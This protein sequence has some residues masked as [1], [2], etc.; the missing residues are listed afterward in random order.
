MSTRNDRSA[1]LRRVAVLTAVAAL[2]M[3]PAGPAQVRAG[4][5]P[6]P[7]IDAIADQT[8]AEG[9]F[10]DVPIHATNPN[11]WPYDGVILHVNIVLSGGLTGPELATLIDHHDGTG[12]LHIA[13]G[14]GTAGTYPGASV[15][16][17]GTDDTTE[18]VFTLTVTQPNRRPV[19]AVIA[20]QTVAEGATKDVDV[21]ASDPDGDAVAISGSLPAFATLTDH[22]DGTA[23][24]HLAPGYSDAGTYANRTVDVYDGHLWGA[25]VAFG[26]TV[27]NTDQTAP[28][29]S[30]PDAI[31]TTAN[32][33]H[34]AVV[35][36]R[37]SASDD[38]DGS[39]VPTCVPPSGS[40]FAVGRTRVTCSVTDSS[41]HTASASFV[42]TV[43]RTAPVPSVPD[44]SA[45]QP[46]EP[47]EPRPA[48]PIALGAVAMAIASLWVAVGRAQRRRAR[49]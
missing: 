31:T 7:T 8:V 9:A 10:A 19:L 46:R 45:G 42:V 4:V 28:V 38:V 2:L 13:P 22:H 35:T 12:I 44:T 24:I 37:V 11:P 25:Q 18:A 6:P 32:V 15:V 26:I 34:G 27:T 47:V 41:G 49:R 29:I 39:L 33:P 17:M 40:T 20:D 23:T 36:Y 48:G 30:V 14:A 1:G 5:Y 16:A 3:M 21:T 43:D